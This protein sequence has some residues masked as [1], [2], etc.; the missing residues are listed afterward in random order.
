MKRDG[1]EEIESE[2]IANEMEKACFVKN[3]HHKYIYSFSRFLFPFFVTY[4]KRL[5]VA[6]VVIV[7]FFLSF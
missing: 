6:L 5:V 1:Q 7:F 2:M 4:N 3:N